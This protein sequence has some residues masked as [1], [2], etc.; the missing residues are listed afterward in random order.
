M[1]RLTGSVGRGGLNR[2]DDVVTLQRLINAK[3]PIPLAPLVEDG[4]CG[5]KTIF[6][7]GEYQRRNLRMNAPDCR[8]DPGGSTFRSLTGGTTGPIG[9]TPPAVPPATVPTVQQDVRTGDGLFR[10]PGVDPR[11][12]GGD[13]R[14][15]P[16]GERAPPGGGWRPRSSLRPRPVAPGPAAPVPEFH[17]PFHPGIDLRRAARLRPARADRRGRG[18]CRESAAERHLRQSGGLDRV[19]ILRAASRPRRRRGPARAAG[20]ADPGRLSLKPRAASNGSEHIDNNKE[21]WPVLSFLHRMFLEEL[22]HQVGGR[23][24]ERCLDTNWR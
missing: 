21:F 12:G 11:P 24:V 9:P 4:I 5:P 15:P 19:A 7:I 2:R 23:D 8:V 16:G 17:R 1:A 20:G 22:L 18:A 10:R 14:Q 6:A 3:L 13:S